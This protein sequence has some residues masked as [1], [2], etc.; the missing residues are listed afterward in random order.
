MRAN[1]LWALGVVLAIVVPLL[2][3]RHWNRPGQTGSPL[4]FDVLEFDA[5]IITNPNNATVR[6]AFTYRNVSSHPIEV[7]EIKTSCGCT[8]AETDARRI[9]PGQIGS[10]DVAMHLTALGETRQ[11][12]VVPIVGQSPI[13]LGIKAV[14]QPHAYATVIPKTLV[15]TESKPAQQLEVQLFSLSSEPARIAGVRAG[16]RDILATS[17]TRPSATRVGAGHYRTSFD[18]EIDTSKIQPGDN[19]VVIEFEQPKMPPLEVLVEHSQSLSTRDLQ[20]P[21][22]RAAHDETH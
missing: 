6:H 9:D 15:L 19:T 21:A 20:S 3:M 2:A 14:F 22:T 8:V 1:G 16:D 4:E 18:V 5:G 10:I 13:S 12:V 11:R 7:G 17:E